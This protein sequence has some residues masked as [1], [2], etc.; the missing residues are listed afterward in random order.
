MPVTLHARS[1]FVRAL[2]LVLIATAISAGGA[3]AAS[4]SGQAPPNIPAARFFGGVTLYGVA[5]PAGAAVAASVDGVV[6]GNG[7]VSGGQYVL[8]LQAF[9]SCGVPG[10]AVNFTVNG[11]TAAQVG[12]VPDIPGTAVPLDLSAPVFAPPPTPPLP[13]P[14]APVLLTPV[15]GRPIFGSPATFQWTGDGANTTFWLYVGSSPG[16][17]NFFDSGPLGPYSTSVAVYGL[18]RGGATLWVRL[19]WNSGPGWQYHDYAFAAY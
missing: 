10:Q 19:W 7:S 15:P 6:C 11:L 2:A 17:A 14:F 12:Y 1:P 5:A 18:P 3:L 16:A 8:D 13:Q 9:S 4:P